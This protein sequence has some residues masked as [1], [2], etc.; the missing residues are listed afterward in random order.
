MS[1]KSRPADQ[2]GKL[3]S[4]VLNDVSDPKRKLARNAAQSA[5][6]PWAFISTLAIQNRVTREIH[7]KLDEL[8]LV[9][10]KAHNDFVELDRFSDD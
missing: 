3:D 1:A 5:G 10:N 2:H 7:L 6:S 9:N 8:I 4:D